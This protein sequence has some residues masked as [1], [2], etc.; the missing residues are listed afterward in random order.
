[1]R[2]LRRSVLVGNL[3]TIKDPSLLRPALSR[4]KILTVQFKSLGDT[5]M[6][7]PT[8]NAIRRNFPNCELH[9]VVPE[10]AAPLLQHHP[11][12]N[13]VWAVPRVRGQA[14]LREVWPIIRALRAE[15]FDACID[16]AGN[17]RSAIATFL[18][19]APERLGVRQQN[20]FWGRR[21]CYTDPV[22]PPP[23]DQHEA[24]R[25]LHTLS[26]WNISPPATIEIKL[27]PD[28]TLPNP[29]SRNQ[30]RPTVI[31]NMGAATAKKQWPLSHWVRLHHLATARGYE[32]VYT[33]GVAPRE[34][35]MMQK[36]QTLVPEAKLLPTLNLAQL[37]VAMQSADAVISNDT[38]PMHFAAG[39]G[40]K[41]IGIFG[42]SSS[43]R[44]SPVG[45]KIRILQ[46]QDCIC[47]RGTFVCRRAEHCMI[48]IAPETVLENLESL[49]PLKSARM[50][51]GA[52]TAMYGSAIY[53]SRRVSANNNDSL[54]KFRSFSI[55]APQSLR[56]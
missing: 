25:L 46:A 27:Y 10:T 12:L 21:F 26:P 20:G 53:S 33:R 38:G 39:L 16:I 49:L 35:E 23:L 15:R 14:R 18:S 43:K 52:M 50:N 22:E 41:T 45:A 13:R 55:S 40:V 24:L 8:L 44:W 5:V 51:N 3:R 28:P 30:D 56:Q 6:S 32:L 11:V 48:H 31:C 42:P 29:F 34:V 37:L 36:F 54:N 19:G 2:T 17:D 7:I 4:L 47:Q 9:A 1:M